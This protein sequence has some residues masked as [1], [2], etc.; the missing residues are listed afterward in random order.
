VSIQSRCLVAIQ[1][2]WDGALEQG[3]QCEHIRPEL[4]PA[5]DTVQIVY[6][7]SD[8]AAWI[9]GAKVGELVQVMRRL[10]EFFQHTFHALRRIAGYG[11]FGLEFGLA[12]V[13][14]D[15]TH[16]GG[17]GLVALVKEA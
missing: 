9:R 2:A 7:V 14:D 15:G 12:G 10:R 1:F 13:D 6:V 5:V 17:P 8:R 16:F 3:S 4:A 11:C